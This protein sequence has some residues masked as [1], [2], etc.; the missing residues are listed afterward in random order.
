MLSPFLSF[1]NTQILMLSQLA[2]EFSKYFE[3]LVDM[4]ERIGDVLPRFRAYER[5]F[6]DNER[7]LH[8]L[9]LV[10]VDILKFCFD[11][12]AVFR[13]NKHPSGN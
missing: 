10:Y 6:P 9:S 11:A 12:K 7:L 3:K 2:R 4:F 1:P 8:S 5:L 13:R